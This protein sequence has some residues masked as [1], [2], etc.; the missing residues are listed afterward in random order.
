MACLKWGLFYLP[1]LHLPIFWLRFLIPLLSGLINGPYG[2]INSF[3]FSKE[4]LE[5][6][7]TLVMGSLDVKALFTSIPLDETIH[8]CTNELFKDKLYI[9]KLSKGDIKTFWNELLKIHSFCLTESYQQ[10]DVVTNIF[11]AYH[12]QK[13]NARLLLNLITTVDTWMISFCS[14]QWKHLT[15]LETILTLSCLRN[16]QKWSE[17]LGKK[18]KFKKP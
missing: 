10:V 4:I 16:F 18:Y 5:Q 1:L 13:M 3:S 11:M 9:K 6:D 8:I 17:T 7:P 15:C 2:I 14:T 12:E